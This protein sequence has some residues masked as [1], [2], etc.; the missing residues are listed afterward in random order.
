VLQLKRLGVGARK[1]WLVSARN[2]PQPS[3]GAYKMRLLLVKRRLRLV[4]VGLGKQL[5]LKSGGIGKRLKLKR[6]RKLTT[7]N[8]RLCRR[9]LS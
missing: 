7:G 4:D 2:K 1:S 9:Q 6:G 5:K 8:G 3:V